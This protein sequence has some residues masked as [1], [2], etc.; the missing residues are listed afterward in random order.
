MNCRS[1]YQ[2]AA[3]HPTC[4][5]IVFTFINV[6]QLMMID[7]EACQPLTILSSPFNCHWT[8]CI[9]KEHLDP[10][11][12][13]WLR[14]RGHPDVVPLLTERSVYIYIYT[15]GNSCNSCCF[16]LFN[17][18]NDVANC[19]LSSSFIHGIS[20]NNIVCAALP[21]SFDSVVLQPDPNNA[22]RGAVVDIQLI[23]K[24]QIIFTS[25][26]SVHKTLAIGLWYMI[27]HTMWFQFYPVLELSDEAFRINI[28]L[29]DAVPIYFLYLKVISL[30]CTIRTGCVVHSL[31]RFIDAGLIEM[32]VA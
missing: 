21:S 32:V 13:F 27:T 12:Q 29:R 19:N 14:C 22:P 26:E 17:V 20:D 9:R 30:L 25:L 3:Y 11:Q 10:C 8:V 15:P 5:N 28:L 24:V 23:C 7:V 2:S 31:K 6:D 1:A 4:E 18:V 16:M